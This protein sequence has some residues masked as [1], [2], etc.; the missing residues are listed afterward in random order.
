MRTRFEGF[1]E[2]AKARHGARWDASDL[3][4]QFIEHYNTGY[5]IEVTTTY[6]NGETHVRRGRIGITTGWKPAFL[7]MSRRGAIGSSDV[8]GVNDVCTSGETF[9]FSCSA[10]S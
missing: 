8:L 4:P 3:A 2:S 1:V 10:D 5:R 7:L 9:C 6:P